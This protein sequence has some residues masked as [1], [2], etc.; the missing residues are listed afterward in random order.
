MGV[1]RPQEAVTALEKALAITKT[2]RPA[3]LFSSTKYVLVSNSEFVA[4]TQEL[5]VK[6]R[7]AAQ[8]K[9]GRMSRNRNGGNGGLE[10]SPSS[11]R[12]RK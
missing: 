8:R 4:E 5:L 10:P 7:E 3:R 9:N 1:G 6:A 11:L 2:V 12:T